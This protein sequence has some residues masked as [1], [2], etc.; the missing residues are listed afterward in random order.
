MYAQESTDSEE[1]QED[2]KSTPQAD[3]W[4][5]YTIKQSKVKRNKI[6]NPGEKGE[7]DLQSYHIIGFKCPCFKEITRLIKK[8][9][10]NELIETIPEKEKMADL[11]GKDFQTTILK[12]LKELKQ[13][14]DKVKIMMY[15]QNGTMNKEKV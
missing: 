7:S 8:Q 13:D 1:T 5:R 12:M 6:A 10:K 3:Y 2:L 9:E 15:E 11:L 4:H 14:V